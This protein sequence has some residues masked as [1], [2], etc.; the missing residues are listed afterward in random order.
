MQ[1]NSEEANAARLSQAPAVI[2]PLHRCRWIDM[3]TVHDYRGNL[4]FLEGSRHVPFDIKRVYYIYDIPSGAERAGH[5][6]RNLSQVFIALSGSFDLVLDDGLRKE[7]VHL[8][9]AHMGFVVVPWVWRVVNNFSGNS[10]C[11]VVASTEYDEDDY[12]RDYGAFIRETAI[13]HGFAHNLGAG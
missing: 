13:R 5:A 3:P 8:N 11:L 1:T 9:R 10:V 12:I 2:S 4:S 6:H 7:T